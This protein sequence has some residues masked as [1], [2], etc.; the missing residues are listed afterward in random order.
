M[1]AGV[2]RASRGLGTSV[3]LPLLPRG[4][5]APLD[6]HLPAAL[7]LLPLLHSPVCHL[8][9]QQAQGPRPSRRGRW[10]ALPA[11]LTLVG[12]APALQQL[13]CPWLPSSLPG[14]GRL[15]LFE[16][17]QQGSGQGGVA[18]R[19]RAWPPEPGGPSPAPAAHPTQRA[20][21]P[22]STLEW[23]SGLLSP[24]RSPS[25]ASQIRRLVSEGSVACP[26][27]Q[28]VRGRGGIRTGSGQLQAP[29]PLLC[30]SVDPQRQRQPG[31]GETCRTR[32]CILPD[33][34]VCSLEH[35]LSTRLRQT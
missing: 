26:V 28:L 4:L 20:M 5:L 35:S 6:G 8:G 22:R 9:S 17:S 21:R 32:I 25:P 7:P 29:G 2:R 33:S 15:L 12:T 18:S 23:A 24:L 31:A 34:R 11:A 30:G 27:A 10:E 14:A 3:H 13:S 19:S 16:E 1:Y